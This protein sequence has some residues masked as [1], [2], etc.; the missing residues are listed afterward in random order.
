MNFQDGISIYLQ[1]ARAIEDDIL[2]GALA[3]EDAVPSTN[4]LSRYYS[5]NPA[6]ALKGINILVD[7]GILYKRRGIGMFIAVGA[8][9]CVRKKR[10]KEFFETQLPDTIAQALK[11][12]IQEDELREAVTRLV[13]E[14]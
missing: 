11:L 3:E 7:E 2:L 8:Q 1:V 5:I 9:D 13:R 6:T 12:G 10:K 14:G 4:E